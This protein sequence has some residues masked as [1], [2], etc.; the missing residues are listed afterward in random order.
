MIVRLQ[1]SDYAEEEHSGQIV[2]QRLER[3]RLKSGRPDIRLLESSG[4]G[5]L[6][7]EFHEVLPHS[8]D[9]KTGPRVR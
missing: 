3:I 9:Q 8:T 2:E 1:S 6:G 5:S 4:G 7:P